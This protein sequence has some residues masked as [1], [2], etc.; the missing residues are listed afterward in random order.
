MKHT[1]TNTHI[2]VGGN[3]NSDTDRWYKSIPYCEFRMLLV[4]CSSEPLYPMELPSIPAVALNRHIQGTP[5][6]T[7]ESLLHI[8]QRA[9]WSDRDRFG[10]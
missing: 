9:V 1:H 4:L 10:L 3:D 5:T 2:Q 8:H 6:S 7:I